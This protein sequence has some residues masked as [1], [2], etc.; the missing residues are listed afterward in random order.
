MDC[1]QSLPGAVNLGPCSVATGYLDEVPFIVSE[2][3]ITLATP[4]I[5]CTHSV[6]LLTQT[7]SYWM[8][9]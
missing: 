5:F 8:G 1:S 3:S 4:L 9:D 7:S 2:V 6:M